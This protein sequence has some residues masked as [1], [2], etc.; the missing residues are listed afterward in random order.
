MPRII[1]AVFENGVIKPLEAVE[2]KEHQR[3]RV[4]I[5]PLPGVVAETRG[6]IQVAS[7]VVEEVAESHDF[8]PF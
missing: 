2:L 6:M 5:T 3:L 4:A 8:I 7:D 1:D